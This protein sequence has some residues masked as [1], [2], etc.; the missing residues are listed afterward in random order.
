[1]WRENRGVLLLEGKGSGSGMCC[2][3]VWLQER[4]RGSGNGNLGEEK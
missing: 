4:G 1:V 2:F 3:G